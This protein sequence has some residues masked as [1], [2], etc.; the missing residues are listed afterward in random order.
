MSMKNVLG[1]NE[2]YFSYTVFKCKDPS[3]VYS[4]SHKIQ[5]GQ[6][7]VMQLFHLALLLVYFKFDIKVCE[8]YTIFSIS[9]FC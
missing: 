7:I 5:I 6:Q 8:L 9:L 1:S 2:S 3:S 4:N